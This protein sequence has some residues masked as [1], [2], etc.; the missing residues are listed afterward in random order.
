MK[1]KK[2]F[3]TSWIIKEEE[4]KEE[5]HQ[6]WEIKVLGSNVKDKFQKKIFSKKKLIEVIKVTRKNKL[7]QDQELQNNGKIELKYY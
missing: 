1:Q 4:L 2:A 6:D 5:N 3:L 7:L